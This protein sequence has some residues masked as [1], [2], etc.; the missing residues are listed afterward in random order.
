MCWSSLNVFLIFWNNKGHA[1][2]LFLCPSYP[3][4]FTSVG[5]FTVKYIG[6][7]LWIA[8]LPGAVQ[9][10]A[11]HLASGLVVLCCYDRVHSDWNS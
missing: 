1:I 6:L 9:L 3:E 10:G 2:L 4:R 8:V 7:F 5:L 11:A